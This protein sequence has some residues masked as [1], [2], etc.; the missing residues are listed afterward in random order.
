MKEFIGKSIFSG[1]AMGKLFCLSNSKEP[2]NAYKPEDLEAELSRYRNAKT[3]ALAQLAALY[4]KIT[5]VIGE[6]DAQIF[7]VHQKAG[8]WCGICGELGAD[9]SLTKTFLEYGLDEISMSPRA[10]LSIRKMIRET[11]SF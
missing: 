3:K 1:M 10:I 9:Q 4:E 11:E 5:S 2:V 8:I 7:Q 6:N